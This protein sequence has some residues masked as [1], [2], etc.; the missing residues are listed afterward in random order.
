MQLNYPKDAL[1]AVGLLAI[2]GW[3][4]QD[5]TSRA[6]WAVL[7]GFAL[8]PPLVMLPF[9]RAPLQAVSEVFHRVPRSH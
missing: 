9:W 3:A 6:A 1:A 4:T 2:C 8:L 7:A 5:V